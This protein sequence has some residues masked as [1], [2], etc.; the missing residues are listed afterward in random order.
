MPVSDGSRWVSMELG[1]LMFMAGVGINSG[2]GTVEVVQSACKILKLNLVLLPLQVSSLPW[3][4]RSSCWFKGK[5]EINPIF[6]KN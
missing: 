6:F 5:R 3:P 4:T 2:G 1:L